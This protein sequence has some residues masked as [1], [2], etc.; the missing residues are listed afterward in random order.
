MV[1]HPIRIADFGKGYIQ[2]D[3]VV[4]TKYLKEKEGLEADVEK[5]IEK[6]KRQI[7]ISKSEP[8]LSA[9]LSNDF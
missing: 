4:M 8:L 5:V 1:C 7:S 6:I 3:P 9:I 2:K